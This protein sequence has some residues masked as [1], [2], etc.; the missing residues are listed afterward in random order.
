MH[1]TTSVVHLLI[2]FTD[3]NIP[4]PRSVDNSVSEMNHPAHADDLVQ[5]LEK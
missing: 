1:I 2:H 5:I 3:K 4:S